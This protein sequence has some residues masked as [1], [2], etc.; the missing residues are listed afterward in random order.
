METTFDMKYL[1]IERILSIL[2]VEMTREM[3]W[4]I[5]IPSPAE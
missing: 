1:E 4:E 2:P 3:L 5:E